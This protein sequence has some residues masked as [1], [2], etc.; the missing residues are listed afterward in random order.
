MANQQ[1]QFRVKEILSIIIQEEAHLVYVQLG[2]HGGG[3]MKPNSQ[4]MEI[5][6]N[7]SWPKIRD[8]NHQS[9]E[10]K[11]KQTVASDGNT[12]NISSKKSPIYCMCSLG[13]MVAV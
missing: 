13:A 4:E 8:N 3:L 5:A 7:R 6:S 11:P 1:T 2:G 10:G 9:K 12:I